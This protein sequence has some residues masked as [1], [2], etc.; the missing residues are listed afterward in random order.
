[1]IL[2]VKELI[3]RDWFMSVA[4]THMQG[5][6]SGEYEDI[7]RQHRDSDEFIILADWITSAFRILSLEE[8]RHAIA[9]DDKYMDPAPDSSQSSPGFL[10]DDLDLS[11][12]V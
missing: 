6:M 8:I 3:R 4:E 10:K 2:C 1:M 7:I 5:N 12:R 9:C 11:K